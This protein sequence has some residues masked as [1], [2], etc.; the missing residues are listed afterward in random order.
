MVK[1]IEEAGVTSA[2]EVHVYGSG[3]PVIAFTAGVH[4]D[5]VTGVYTARRLMEHLEKNPPIKGTVR[6]LPTV[7]PAAMRCL[8]RRSPFD[9]VDLN[10]VFPGDQTLSITHRVAKAAW[11]ETEDADVVVDLHCCSQYLLP[12]I[13]SVYDEFEKL[14]AFISRITMP[15]AI[16][17]EGTPGQLFT[18]SCRK[19]GQF[20]CVIELPSGPSDGVINKTDSDLCFSALLDLLR[21]YGVLEGAVTGAP[22]A[23]YDRL[24]DV[25]ATRAGLWMP[26]VQKGSRVKRGNTLGTLD[27]APVSAPEDALVMAV[28][29]MSYLFEGNLWVGT[30]AKV[31]E[32]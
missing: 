22:P 26:T 31:R 29:P 6:V 27:S 23:F 13:L 24:T 8:S 32:G 5:E 19:R 2:L 3:K 16:R 1:H 4:G 14:P 7:N 11:E 9:K 30:Y 25:N 18:E 20:T 10:R 21:A 17:S 28:L 15:V 12:Y